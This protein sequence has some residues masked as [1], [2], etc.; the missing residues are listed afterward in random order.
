MAHI[1]CIINYGLRG[2]RNSFTSDMR[3]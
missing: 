2:A 3:L 1:R